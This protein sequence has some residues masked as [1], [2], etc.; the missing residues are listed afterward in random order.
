VFL[1]AHHRDDESWAD[2]ERARR[3]FEAAGPRRMVGMVLG[4]EGELR[5]DQGRN[6]EA[7][8]T[9]RAALAEQEAAL[10]PDHPDLSRTLGTLA[11]ALIAD[12]PKSVEAQHALE[13]SLSIQT[14]AYGEHHRYTAWTRV[15][16]G[17]A[18]L[19]SG[20]LDEA[21]AA[22]RA[23]LADFERQPTPDAL[24]L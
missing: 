15:N 5:L 23:S 18:L 24:P 9:L 22:C 2:F 1:R 13:R 4:G 3:A 17:A 16:L 14:R 7:A 19:S 6:Q 8:A 10:G 12:D 21:E 20:R 11:D